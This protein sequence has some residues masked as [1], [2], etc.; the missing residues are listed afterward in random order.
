VVLLSMLTK[1]GWLLTLQK[2]SGW[3]CKNRDEN[4]RMRNI[5]NSN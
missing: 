5:F 1:R 3:L 4:P 2:F